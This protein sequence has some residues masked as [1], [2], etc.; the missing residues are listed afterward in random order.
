MKF[1]SNKY[2]V[3]LITRIYKRSIWI[4]VIKILKMNETKGILEKF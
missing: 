1:L 4:E 2:I 3:I